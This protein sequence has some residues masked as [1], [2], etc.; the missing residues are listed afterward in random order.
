MKPA[1]YISEKMP[2][3]NKVLA[4]VIF[5]KKIDRENKPLQVIVIL[6]KTNIFSTI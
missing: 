6:I 4:R 5:I 1:L 2:S 3:L